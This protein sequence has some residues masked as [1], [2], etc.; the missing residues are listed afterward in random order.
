MARADPGQ[1]LDRVVVDP[2]ALGR[3]AVVDEH[4]VSRPDGIPAETLGDGRRRLDCLGRGDVREVGKG[5]SVAHR[6]IVREDQQMVRLPDQGANEGPGRVDHDAT[7]RQPVI[8]RHK[9]STPT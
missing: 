1:G 6:R 5:N 9:S 3:L 8:L 4:V 7:V 2:V